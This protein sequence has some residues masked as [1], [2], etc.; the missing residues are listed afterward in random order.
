M[1]RRWKLSPLLG[2]L[3][4]VGFAGAAGGQGIPGNPQQPGELAP[5][6]DDFSNVGARAA[7]FLTIPV[8]ARG[9]ALGSAFAAAADD[10]TSIYWNPAGLAFMER[11]EAFY[12]FVN[13]PLNVNL[14]YAAI[15][16]PVFGGV[17]VVGGFF[18]LL[19]LPSQEI[20]TVLQPEGT[21]ILFESNSLAAG[22]S[23]AHNISDRFS[24]GATAKVVNESI[25]D[26]DG[27]ALAFDF[28]SNYHTTLFGR[29]IRL[30][31]AVQNI[32]S[33]L[34]LEGTRLFFDSDPDD[35]DDRDNIESPIVKLP[36]NLFPRRN[37]GAEQRT[38]SFTLPAV[39]KTG[40][41]YAVLEEAGNSLTLAGEF[42]NPNNQEEVFALGAEYRRDL[43]LAGGGTEGSEG[44]NASVS[45]RGGWFF[46]QDEIDLGDSPNDS[47]SLRGLSLGAGLM[48][49]FGMFSAGLDYAYRDLGRI[50]QN[51]L[52]SVSVG[53]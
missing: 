46:Q 1:T 12:T 41:S 4:V 8:G 15:A 16:T 26:V 17:G 22:L 5:A 40:V 31:F 45:L 42:W 3:L 23:Y 51:N 19:D 10:I 49:D 35:L 34:K 28:G 24:A 47:D 11:P 14:S 44:R 36:D 25:A 2:L 9:T 37:R 30:A 6:D 18:E 32:G 53:L 43:A 21:G 52:F 29:S 13:M 50:T 39:F 48:Y 38:G 7:E 27:T 33:E 20:T